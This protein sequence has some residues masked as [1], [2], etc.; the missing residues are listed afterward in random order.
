L[1]GL[2]RYVLTWLETLP[3]TV[4]AQ[5][6]FA[7]TPPPESLTGR[8]RFWL[9]ATWLSWRARAGQRVPRPI[10]YTARGVA[11]HWRALFAS[12]LLFALGAFVLWYSVSPNLWL[13][14]ALDTVGQLAFIR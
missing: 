4:P 3:E 2:A 13:Q 14:R 10:Q 8:M 9:R 5:D 12:I 11:E 1:I 6:A 7:P